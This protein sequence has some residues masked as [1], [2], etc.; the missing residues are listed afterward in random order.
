MKI[1]KGYSVTGKTIK[2]EEYLEE[3]MESREI[4]NLTK[5]GGWS[6]EMARYPEFSERG[7]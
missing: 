3:N 1:S 6:S 2:A 7:I 4:F 5:G